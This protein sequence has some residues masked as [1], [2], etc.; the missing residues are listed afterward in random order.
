MALRW[1]F[2]EKAGTVTEKCNGKEATH[3]F[4]VG[5]AFMIVTHEFEEEGEERYTMLWF[6]IGEDHA[7][8]CLGLSKGHDNM[9][10]NDGITRLTIYRDNCP[11][12]KK[13]IDLFVKAFP[14]IAIEL[15]DTE[16]KEE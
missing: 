7:K 13:I 10:G 16:A 9:F 4:Y 3:N 11:N 12:W 2:T 1:D 6:F 14:K 8:N 5:N 15:L